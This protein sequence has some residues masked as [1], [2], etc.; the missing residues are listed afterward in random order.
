MDWFEKITGFRELAYEQTRSRLRVENGRLH[1]LNSPRSFGVGVLETPSLGELRE[2]VHDVTN[3]TGR[4]KVSCLN[5][6]V[7]RMHADPRNEGALFQV[8]SQ[9]N[10]LE[11][12]SEH[13]TPEHGVTRYE[14]D[15][16]QGPACA[17]AAGAGTIYRNYFV[18]VEGGIGQTRKRQI[19]CLKDLGA[20][21]GNA[22]DGMLWTMQNGYAMCTER[23]LA[24]VDELL[25]ACTPVE[26]DALRAKLRIGLH[27]NVELTEREEPGRC[28]TQAYCSALPVSYSHLPVP[29]RRW[30]RFATLVLEAAYEAILLAALLNLEQSRSVFLTRLGG[31]AFGNDDQWI[32]VAMTRALELVRNSPLDVH[33]VGRAPPSE[34]IR[35][36][37]SHYLG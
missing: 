22:E 12:I 7:R 27:W 20:A 35:R 13:V 28:V 30:G 10:L 18:P 17:I 34:D 23:G 2:R 5:G 36:L 8:A 33:I 37:A 21:L 6:D 4:L 15:P 9:F 11:M 19:D 3:S 25:A 1:S 26:L 24:A 32:L 16:T 29:R 14:R 31:G